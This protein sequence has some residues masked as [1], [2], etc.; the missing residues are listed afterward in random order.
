MTK[1]R[2]VR[3]TDDALNEACGKLLRFLRKRK[4]LS[5]AEVS[6]QMGVSTTHLND[7]E[8]GRYAARLAVLQKLCAMYGVTL[9]QF[10]TQLERLMK[11]KNNE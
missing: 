1:P 11:E 9:V 8:T 2:A 4:A 7:L 5:V 3:L 6:A 10:V